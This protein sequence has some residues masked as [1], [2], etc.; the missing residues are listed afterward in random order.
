[1]MMNLTIFLF[2][3]IMAVSYTTAFRQGQGHNQLQ[4]SVQKRTS[5]LQMNFFKDLKQNLVKS[6]AGDYDEQKVTK[7][8]DSY[9]ASSKK[10]VTMLS[11]ETCPFCV[12]AR[13]ALDARGIKYD[14]VMIDKLPDGKFLRV[15]MGKRFGQTSVPAIWINEDFVGGCNNGGMG[16]LMPLMANG[17]L[18]EL[19]KFKTKK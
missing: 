10:G 9:I 18:D 13:Q 2:F 8:L 15:E 4:P 11:F 14:D 5:S 3:L 1:M 12:K 6:I 19:L 16:G 17:K 7:Q